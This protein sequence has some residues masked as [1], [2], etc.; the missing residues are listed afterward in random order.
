MH[1]EC[2]PA[3]AGKNAHMCILP[4]S[5]MTVESPDPSGCLTGVVT[6]VATVTSQQE[7][8]PYRVGVH[9][10]WYTQEPPKQCFCPMNIGQR[11]TLQKRGTFI[12]IK[13]VSVK[14]IP[15]MQPQAGY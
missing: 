8:C 3:P 12:N 10:S 2:C 14:F 15:A 13:S 5:T 4:G 6:V 9:L 7:A 11:R 1:T